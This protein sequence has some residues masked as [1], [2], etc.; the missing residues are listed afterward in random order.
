MGW[1]GVPRQAALLSDGVVSPGL[2]LQGRSGQRA[3]GCS[4][5]CAG[6]LLPLP[7]SFTTFPAV[8]GQISFLCKSVCSEKSASFP[9]CI[10]RVFL[11]KVILC[12]LAKAINIGSLF[13]KDPT[14]L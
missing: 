9:K 5:R 11:I 14:G 12:L 2:Q 8:G 1:R 10:F 3:A 13:I 4:A 6:G 7:A